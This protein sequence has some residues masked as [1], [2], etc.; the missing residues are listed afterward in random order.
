MK[1]PLEHVLEK[2]EVPTFM[3]PLRIVL[4]QSKTRILYFTEDHKR[5]KWFELLQ[6]QSGN[7]DIENFY[8]LGKQLGE[9]QFG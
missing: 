5:L 7:K 4:G 1:E 6:E 3:F 2:N 8:T 9:G